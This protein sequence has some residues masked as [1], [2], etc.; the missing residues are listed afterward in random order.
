MN[1]LEYIKRDSH[2]TL[3]SQNGLNFAIYKVNGSLIK[4]DATLCQNAVVFVKK[5]HK[6]LHYKNTKFEVDADEIIFLS[7]GIHTLSDIEDNGEYIAH[8]VFFSNEF[9]LELINKHKFV[10]QNKRLKSK[11]IYKISQDI[12][13]ANFTLNLEL[14]FKNKSPYE[15]IKHKFEELFLSLTSRVEFIEFLN[16][17]Y[18][19]YLFEFQ[20]IFTADELE[21]DSVAQMAKRVNMDISSFSRKFSKI[22]N[23][24][25]KQYLDDRRFQKALFLLTH[26]NQNI[27][28]ICAQVGFSTTSW[29]IARFKERYN[30]SPKQ[31]Q[32]SKNLYFLA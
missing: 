32:K 6:N 30:Q 8:I 10:L 26:T 31:F 5:G 27:S 12:T 7:A 23:I 21:F 15:L 11:K 17:I 16:E 22:F 19:I 29:F 3:Y 18:Q 14:Y 9:L 2:S 20:K 1:V 13:L 24:A 4:Y 28:Q 25:P